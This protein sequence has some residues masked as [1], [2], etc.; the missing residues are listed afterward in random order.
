MNTKIKFYECTVCGNIITYFLKKDPNVVCCG[1]EMVELKPNTTDASKEKHVPAYNIN[2]DKVKVKIGSI[3]HPMADDHYIQ[4]ILI[5]TDKGYY[6]KD[7]KPHDYPEAEFTLGK[8]ENVVAVYDYC[9]IHG[10]WVATEEY[11]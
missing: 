6:K 9:N 2:E 3:E 10:L 1:K 7:L 8:D 4:W 5:E 11:K